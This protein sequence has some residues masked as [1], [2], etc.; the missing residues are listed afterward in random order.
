MSLIER[1]R[2]G[3]ITRAQCRDMDWDDFDIPRKMNGDTQEQ[4][5]RRR[6]AYA[7]ELCRGCPVVDE[8]ARDALEQRDAEIIRAGVP[9]PQSGNS[10]WR[11]ARAAL[12]L[13][14]HGVPVPDAA[15]H[16]LAQ[17]ARA[18]PASLG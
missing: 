10:S 4:S 14:A 18:F 13:I 2:T 17:P 6:W 11:R 16:V 3:W 12:D 8:C 1:V 15:S 9:I 5:L 7:G